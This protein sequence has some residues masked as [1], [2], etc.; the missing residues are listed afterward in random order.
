M[1]S[2]RYYTD[3]SKKQ[4]ANTVVYADTESEAKQKFA[5]THLKAIIISIVRR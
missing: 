1:Y 3:E 4:T 2:I 5:N